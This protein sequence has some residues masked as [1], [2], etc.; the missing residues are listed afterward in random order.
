VLP[1]ATATA[2][3]LAVA[4]DSPSKATDAAAAADPSLDESNEPPVWRGFSVRT[5][6]MGAS[7]LPL[8]HQFPLPFFLFFV[9]FLSF[10]TERGAAVQPPRDY[11][12]SLPSLSLFLSFSLSFF[13]SFSFFLFLTCTKLS[14]SHDRVRRSHLG[15]KVKVFHVF[16][17][18]H[19][20]FCRNTQF[21]LKK[22][23]HAP[24]TVTQG[25][26]R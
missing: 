8:K 5:Q 24:S 15:A 19:P 14:P 1:K 16:F 4:E 18:S 25:S 9:F 13:F 17:L 12:L 23:P 2:A 6:P 11:R 10:G 3:R 7:C 20:S 22:Y 26:E 21:F